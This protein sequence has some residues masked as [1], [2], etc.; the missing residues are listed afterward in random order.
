MDSQRVDV[1]KKNLSFGEQ[2]NMGTSE[3]RCPWQEWKVH[4]VLGAVT[5]AETECLMMARHCIAYRLPQQ[6]RLCMSIS[7]HRFCSLLKATRVRLSITSLL[8]DT[9]NYAPTLLGS[10][11]P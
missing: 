5:Q 3:L 11:L 9:F 10:L 1:V 8:K 4:V 2:K 6:K 7:S